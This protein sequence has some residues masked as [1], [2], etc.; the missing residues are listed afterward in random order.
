MFC[1]QAHMLVTCIYC[2]V[3]VDVM[4]I[5]DVLLAGYKFKS[6][7]YVIFLSVKTEFVQAMMFDN[8]MYITV[9]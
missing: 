9:F 8:K 1:S 7:G 2:T 5:I 3:F 6:T 4:H